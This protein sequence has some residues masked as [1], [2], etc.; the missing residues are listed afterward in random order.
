MSNCDHTLFRVCVSVFMGIHKIVL[1]DRVNKGSYGTTCIHEHNWAEFS[2]CSSRLPYVFIILMRSSLFIQCSLE[3]VHWLH[4]LAKICMS[5]KHLRRS[6]ALNLPSL[7]K[8]EKEIVFLKL[9]LLPKLCSRIHAWFWYV[10]LLYWQER[11]VLTSCWIVDKL[12]ICLGVICKRVVSL[13]HLIFHGL[14]WI[15]PPPL[16]LRDPFY[17]PI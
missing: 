17:I 16:S 11:L 10:L 8:T 3:W 2:F 15:P 6:F 4:V 9:N 13:G 1:V 5:N 14:S 12:I 7:W